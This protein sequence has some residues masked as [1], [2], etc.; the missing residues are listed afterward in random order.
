[1]TGMESS[2]GPSPESALFDRLYADPS[3][4]CQRGLWLNSG[5]RRKFRGW[6]GKT[7]GR[8]AFDKWLERGLRVRDDEDFRLDW[9]QGYFTQR[10]HGDN[11]R[12][13]NEHF[14]QSMA[15]HDLEASVRQE[16]ISCR[17]R[18][19]RFNAYKVANG[20]AAQGIK[21]TVSKVRT[22]RTEIERELG[23]VQRDPQDRLKPT[24]PRSFAINIQKSDGPAA[25]DTPIIRPYRLIDYTNGDV[26]EAPYQGLTLDTEAYKELVE[27]FVYEDDYEQG[28]QIDLTYVLMTADQTD[29]GRPVLCLGYEY[30][31]DA[32]VPIDRADFVMQLTSLLAQRAAARGDM[33]A[34]DPEQPLDPL[35]I[36]YEIGPRE[37]D[38]VAGWCYWPNIKVPQEDLGE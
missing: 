26:T 22:L 17:A 15:Q 34:Y 1:M 28:N 3:Q 10:K 33:S 13:I 27:A 16:V 9:V 31:K 12:L 4:W 7:H 18:G 24:R 25:D 11:A 5:E 21:V 23:P 37:A 36:W 20:F 35:E 38:P 32:D 8:G 14:R 6:C 29:D 30:R 2:E 19:V